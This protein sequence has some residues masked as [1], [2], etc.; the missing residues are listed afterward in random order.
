MFKKT[1]PPA[2][3][4]EA[5]ILEVFKK[6]KFGELDELGEKVIYMNNYIEPI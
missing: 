5:F 6:Y 2:N 3:D 4:V 1:Y